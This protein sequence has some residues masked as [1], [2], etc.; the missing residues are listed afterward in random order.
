MGSVLGCIV[1]RAYIRV[2]TL[3]NSFMSGKGLQ[4]CA[5]IFVCSQLGGPRT[6]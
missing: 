5:E 6:L 1:Y 4:G 2:P 3:W